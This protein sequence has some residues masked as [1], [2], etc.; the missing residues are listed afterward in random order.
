MSAVLIYDFPLESLNLELPFYACPV[1]AGFPAPADDHQEAAL[2]LSRHLFANPAATFLARVTG[3]SMIGAGIYAGDL[4]AV[5]RAISPTDGHIVVAVVDGEHTLKRLRL[6]D[7]RIWLEAENDDYPA[8]EL[9][10]GA[11][12][13]VWGVVTHVIH[14]LVTK[15]SA[16]VRPLPPRL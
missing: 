2:D 6:R 14:A 11:R 5:D 1:P 3:D 10:A 16:L 9:L 13:D 7:G 8:L 15:K 12:L 4:I